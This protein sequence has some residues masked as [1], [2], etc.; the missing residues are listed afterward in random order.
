MNAS[1]RTKTLR[2]LLELSEQLDTLN[3]HFKH[4]Q[5]SMDN[6]MDNSVRLTYSGYVSQSK[7]KIEDTK[8]KMNGLLSNLSI[9]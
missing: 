5:E 4:Q 8:T 7:L 1:E 9:D 6:A 3:K 2:Q